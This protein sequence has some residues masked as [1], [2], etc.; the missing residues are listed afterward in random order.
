MQKDIEH[1]ARTTGRF[2]LDGTECK[3]VFSS[4]FRCFEVKNEGTSDIIVS[5]DSGKTAADNGVVVIAAQTSA[6]LAH[7]RSDV[8]TLY[9]TGMGNVQVLAKNEPAALFRAAGGGGGSVTIN[10]SVV[11]ASD[12]NGNIKVDGAEVVVYDDSE[13]IKPMSLE[14]YEALTVEEQ[15]NGTLYLVDD[16]EALPVNSYYN[17]TE[18]NALLNSR[19]SALLT[20]TLV[21]TDTIPRDENKGAVTVSMGNITGNYIIDLECA[22]IPE[23]ALYIATLMGGANA[24]HKILTGDNTYC[25]MDMPYPNAFTIYA[26]DAADIV[27]K[28]YKL[29]F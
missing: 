27:Y 13:K 22:G 17:K 11:T 15:T 16:A 6:T 23:K 14:E 9:L 25:K 8:S 24:W 4:P 10:G 21:S 12:T 20:S 5:L 28:I 18:I 29:P 3:V 2:A 1:G 26:S 7:M 19:L